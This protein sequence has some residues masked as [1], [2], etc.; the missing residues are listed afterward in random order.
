MRQPKESSPK[1]VPKHNVVKGGTPIVSAG[2][3]QS[4]FLDPTSVVTKTA[5]VID[6]TRYLSS[7]PFS[8]TIS[9]GDSAVLLDQGKSS[10]IESLSDSPLLTDIESIAYE[11]YLEPN[12]DI[13]KYRA[14][15]KIR[16]SSV[17]KDN[18]IGVDARI[19]DPTAP[20]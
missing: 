1:R 15:L 7:N 9:P 6:Y 3:L 18:V 10:V 5:G 20:A 14:I 16:N 8:S 4:I 13:I 19:Y 11:S 12:T 2:S 17:K